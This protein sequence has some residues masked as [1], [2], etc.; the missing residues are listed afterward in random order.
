MKI[1]CVGRNYV[2]HINELGNKKSSFPV[3]FIKPDSSLILKNNP[4][5]IP[6]FAQNI[7]H[8]IEFIVKISKVGKHIQ[9]K[10][11]YKYYNQIGI[12]IDFT[13]R[14]L[15][16]E[17]QSKGLPWE[18]AKAFDGSCFLGKWIDKNEFLDLG[19]INF[20]LKKNGKIRQSS[21]TSKMIWK[22]NDLISYIS[23]YFTL[24]I[25]DIVFTGTPSGVGNVEKNDL[26]EGFI[27]NKK[28]FKLEVK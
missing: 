24:K 10:F 22:I 26:L 28:I 15:Q 8:E 23:K 21:N 17:L 5:L 4:F 13:A 25:G 1:I 14:T 20:T 27:E 16:K 2:E 6:D 12:G 3:L 7:Q 18:K 11:S 19:N 9:S